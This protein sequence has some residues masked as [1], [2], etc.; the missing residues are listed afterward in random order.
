MLYAGMCISFM[1]LCLSNCISMHTATQHNT[2]GRR[3]IFVSAS[4]TIHPDYT[5]K[6]S[7]ISMVLAH[8]IC[9]TQILKPGHHNPV[10]QAES[11]PGLSCYIQKS[12]DLYLFKWTYICLKF[13]RLTSQTIYDTVWSFLDTPETSL[14]WRDVTFGWLDPPRRKGDQTMGKGIHVVSQFLP[15]ER[16][17]RL[18]RIK[19]S[20]WKRRIWTGEY[21]SWW[22]VTEAMV[23][24]WEAF[25]GVGE[26]II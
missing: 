2:T 17:L 18:T 19:I 15:A 12:Y 4:Y 14:V 5:M 21:G 3:A 22:E 20:L 10:L 8:S 23:V 25:Q 1:H 9:E 13:V 16:V 11:K 26:G 7:Y 6:H 24:W